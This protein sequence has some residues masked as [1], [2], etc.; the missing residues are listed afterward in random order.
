MTASEPEAV[1]REVYIAARPETIFPFFTDP[2]KMLR[3]KGIEATLDARAG[4]VYRVK[5]NERY[6]ARGE[7][8]AVEPYTR[9]VFTWGW[10]DEGNPVPP[11]SSTVE[12]TLTPESEGTRVRL[13]HRD[14]PAAARDEH[15]AGWEHYL[16]RLAVATPGGDPG[17]DPEAMDVME[18]TTVN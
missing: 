5:V 9:I 17:P 1:V 8:V 7:Y 18:S 13:T 6:I 14:L 2:E 15:A 16:A 11:G 10:E 3:W 12:V 4:G